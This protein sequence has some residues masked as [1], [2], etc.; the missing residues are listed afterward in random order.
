[1]IITQPQD[2]LATWLC[3]RIGLVPSYNLRCIGSLSDRDPEHLRGVVGYDSY[4]EA[5]CIMHMAGEPGWIDKRML[6]AA[7]DYPFNVMGC[8]QVLAFVP[9]DNVVA[10]DIDRRLG[11][12]L[13][14]EL[15]GAHPDGSLFLMRMRREECKWLAPR[16]TH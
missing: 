11:F 15:D 14:C 10:L 5:S 16:R 6:H 9:S 8:N 13:V 2:A 4:N 12:K 7:F 3:T 1:V